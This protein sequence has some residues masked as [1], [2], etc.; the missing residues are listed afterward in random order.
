MQTRTGH[1]I[2]LAALPSQGDVLLQELNQLREFDPLYWSEQSQCWIVSGHAE[3]FE[4]FSG[5]LPLSS[6]HIPKSLY[7][8]M[9][10]AELHARLPN[11][12][13]YM[14]RMVTN[15]DGEEHALM[16]K[17]LVKALNRK[18][19]D[20]Q[21]P[22]VEQ[23]IAMLLDNAATR[24]ELEFHEEIARMLP[25]AVIL[26]LIGLPPE[27]LPRLK[28]WADGV[29][30]ALTSFNPTH[31]WLDGL[32]RV[33]ND[34]IAVFSEQIELHKRLPQADLITQL[35]EAS[36]GGDRLTDEDILGTLILV[37][38]AG[39][40]TTTNTLTLGARTLAQHPDA[41]RYWRE[42]PEKSI[43]C[44]VELMRHIAMSTTLPRIVARDFEWK[45]RQLHAGD[46]LMLMVAGGNRDPRIFT[47]PEALDFARAND[48]ALTFG[49]G[50]HH[51]VG[52]LLAKLQ[53]SEFFTALVQRFERIE[54]LEQPTFTPALVFRSLE[55]LKVRFHPR[56]AS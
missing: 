51:C 47:Q 49:P 3:V 20:S 34:M 56:M 38:V 27:Y 5:T 16:R 2:N 6:T 46:L 13:R 30:Q 26:R 33:V 50:L 1:D 7:R 36:D 21:R 43:D 32:E 4:G 11:A 45:G 52:H 48:L 54:I 19:V 29:T 25:G 39:H 23:R 15:L 53:V 9:E 14:P 37:I 10:P 55:A 12:M 8:V 42:H 22:Y 24:R 18:L 31:E 44:S 17:L 40:D 35:I 41:W 28:G